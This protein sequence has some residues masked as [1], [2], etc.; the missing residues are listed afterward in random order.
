VD[1]E[2]IKNRLEIQ[3]NNPEKVNYKINLFIKNAEY[4]I[5]SDDNS[6]AC[7]LIGKITQES[8]A[9]RS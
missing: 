9:L 5:K 1:I 8:L 2:G 4:I 3:V 6:E 7:E